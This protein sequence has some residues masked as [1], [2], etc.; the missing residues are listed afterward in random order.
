MLFCQ[1][2]EDIMILTR[3][4][5]RDPSPQ[6]FPLENGSRIV[7]KRGFLVLGEKVMTSNADSTLLPTIF[8]DHIQ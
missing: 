7:R 3:C 5:G 2:S 1:N 6:L 4:P 8:S